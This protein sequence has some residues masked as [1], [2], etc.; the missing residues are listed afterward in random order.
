MESARVK[1][2]TI[3]GPRKAT[4]MARSFSRSFRNLLRRVTHPGS[5]KRSKSARHNTD[6]D[7]SNVKFHCPAWIEPE[8][9]PEPEPEIHITITEVKPEVALE[10]SSEEIQE[11]STLIDEM[12]GNFDEPSEE[13]E[14]KKVKIEEKSTEPI[15]VESKQDEEVEE[16]KKKPTV[17]VLFNGIPL[18]EQ[19]ELA[20]YVRQLG[21]EVVASPLECTHMVM[22]FLMISATDVA[23][24]QPVVKPDWIRQS[25]SVG[26]FLDERPFD[27]VTFLSDSTPW[28]Y[29]LL[30]SIKFILIGVIAIVWLYFL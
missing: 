25:Y 19:S 26:H 13:P 17:L 28:T 11:I 9:K 24:G 27:T 15:P 23:G 16:G 10:L 5:F 2:S 29:K 4:R 21:G 8:M 3:R 20:S 18:H 12:M 1:S 30:K 14:L 7:N 22:N 6:N